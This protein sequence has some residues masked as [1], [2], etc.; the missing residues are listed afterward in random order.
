MVFNLLPGLPVKIA[1]TPPN[2]DD[3]WLALDR[4]GNGTI[5]SGL[6]LFGNSTPQAQPPPG[7]HKNGFLALGEYDLPAKGG[8]GDG[9]INQSDAIFT[10]LRLWQDKNHNAI[11]EP[12][13]LHSLLDFGIAAVDCKY[14]DSKRTDEHGNQYRYRAKVENIHGAQNGRWAWDVMLKMAP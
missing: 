6:E 14:K 1:W 13:E 4:D 3:A 11:S 12:S 8:N 9:L 2:T 7:I 10:S 5:D